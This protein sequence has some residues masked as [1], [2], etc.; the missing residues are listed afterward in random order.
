M[1]LTY[2][3]FWFSY[4]LHLQH[5]KAP[6]LMIHHCINNIILINSALRHGTITRRPLTQTHPSAP[7]QYHWTSPPTFCAC[8]LPTHDRQNNTPPEPHASSLNVAAH[9]FCACAL[10]KHDRKHKTPLRAASINIERRRP[11][12][13]P[14]R[15]RRTTANTT[16]PSPLHSSP[17]NVV[18]RILCASQTI[19][20]LQEA[21]FAS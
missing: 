10:P 16:H 14:A 11:H 7:I 1:V 15:C 8:T 6:Y 12:F 18:A 5:C 20:T 4:H 17:L 2:P 21:H 9:I 19:K 13:V 3:K